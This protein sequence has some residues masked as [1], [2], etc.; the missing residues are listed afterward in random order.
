M[1][2]DG[3]STWYVTACIYYNLASHGHVPGP[4][5]E[6]PK[7]IGSYWYVRTGHTKAC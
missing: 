3:V 7:G 6:F 2:V 4:Y 1:L 5:K